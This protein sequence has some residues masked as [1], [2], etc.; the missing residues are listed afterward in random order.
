MS[1]RR[2]IEFLAGE[3]PTGLTV[4]PGLPAFDVGQV[5]HDAADAHAFVLDGGQVVGRCSTWWQ[6]TPVHE[7]G[8]W[9]LSVITPHWMR[10]RRATCSATPAGR[11]SVEA[12]PP[13]LGRWTAAH[14]GA[15]AW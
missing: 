2:V 11:S 15:T 7:R 8:N 1:S 9:A 3:T 13:S 4:H 14:G 10:A 6:R 12:A 5:Q